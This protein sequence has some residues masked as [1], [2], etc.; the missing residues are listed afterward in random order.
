MT[1]IKCPHCRSS[2]ALDRIGMHFQKFC[3]AIPTPEARE[4]SMKKYNAFYTQL[5]SHTR[6]EIT[7]EELQSEADRLFL[8]KK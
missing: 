3:P 1:G 7:V 2:L 8:G 4:A 5:Q 6:G